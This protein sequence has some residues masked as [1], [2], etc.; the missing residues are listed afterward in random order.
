MDGSGFGWLS[1]S[2]VIS[3]FPL[4]EPL[5]LHKKIK[6]MLNQ[7]TSMYKVNGDSSR[8]VEINFG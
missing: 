1:H 2:S 7:E 6:Q 5:A 4:P 3:K 8:L